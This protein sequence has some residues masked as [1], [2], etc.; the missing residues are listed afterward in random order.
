MRTYG[1]FLR[2]RHIAIPRPSFQQMTSLDKPRPTSQFNAIETQPDFIANGK[3][4]DF[5]LEGLSWLV[6]R[7]ISG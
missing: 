6:G 2:F 7:A 3:L 5:Q 1:I 4:M